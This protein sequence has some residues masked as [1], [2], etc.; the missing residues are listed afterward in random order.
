MSEQE[1]HEVRDNIKDIFERIDITLMYD[2]PDINN[3]EALQLPYQA[4]TLVKNQVW[5]CVNP[6][7]FAIFWLLSV[8]NIY[9]PTVLYEY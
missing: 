1:F 3:F 2:N 6:D 4:H 9:I 7:L 5:E 8:D